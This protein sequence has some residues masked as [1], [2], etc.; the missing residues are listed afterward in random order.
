ME[1]NAEA[2]SEEFAKAD[3]EFHLLLVQGSGNPVIIKV[4]DIIKWILTYYQYSANELIG[5]K[6]GVM[7]HRRIIE[8]IEAKDEELAALLMRRHIQRSKHQS[9]FLESILLGAI[10]KL[11][12]WCRF[13]ISV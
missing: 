2:S 11:T 12:F 4:M 5:P 8:V 7:E 6:S 10:D 1:M 13:L 3:L 9:F